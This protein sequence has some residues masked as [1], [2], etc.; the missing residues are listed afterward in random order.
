M[1][2]SRA[3]RRL[4]CSPGESS[5]HARVLMP[6]HLLGHCRTSVLVASAGGCTWFFNFLYEVS[7]CFC[8]TS[9]LSI[10]SFTLLSYAA[11]HLVFISTAP[12]HT[13]F[14]SSMASWFRY[15]GC[16]AVK[17]CASTMCCFVMFI[18]GCV[19]HEPLNIKAGAARERTCSC[20]SVDS[21]LAGLLPVCA[22]TQ[23]EGCKLVCRYNVKD[24]QLPRIQIHDPVA[25]YGTLVCMSQHWI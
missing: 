1:R 14:E 15:F 21:G 22:I 9:H 16:G 10:E 19:Q 11:L 7:T 13:C 2:C 17:L 12:H 5:P 20:G 25:R 4:S 3:S 24:T 23:S 8:S 6:N 18:W